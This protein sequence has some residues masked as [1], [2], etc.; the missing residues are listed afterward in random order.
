MI[1]SLTLNKKRSSEM[2]FKHIIRRFW[3]IPQFFLFF[4]FCACGI[5]F[6][7]E[8][9]VANY[10]FINRTLWNFQIKSFL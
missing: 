8:K 10:S 4:L 7:V 9:N 1:L 5:C 6:G 3:L 2:H